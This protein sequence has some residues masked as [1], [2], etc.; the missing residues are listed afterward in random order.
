MR[1]AYDYQTFTQQ[2]YGGISRYYVRLAEQLSADQQQVRIFA[3]FHR[4]RHVDELPKGLLQGTQLDKFPPRTARLFSMWNR[5][6]SKGSID[7]W[8]PDVVHETYYAAKPS[9]DEHLPR[10]VTIHDMIH[11]R[12]PQSFSRFDHSSD[13]KRASLARA[14]H[15][16]CI[17]QNTKRDLMELFGTPEEKIS[18]IYHGFDQMKKAPVHIDSAPGTRPFLLYVGHRGGYKNF[19]GL[20]KAVASSERLLRDFDIVAFGGGGFTQEEQQMFTE[21]KFKEGQIRQVGGSDENLGRL[22]DEAKAFVYPSVYEGFGLPPLE[23][24]A[25]R[26]PVMSSNSSSMPEVISDAAAFFDPNNI[27]NIRDVLETELYSDT[28]LQDLVNKGVERLKH[29]S[30]DKCAKETLTAYHKAAG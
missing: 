27:D 18:V 13:L 3:P 6:V 11:E 25:H 30:W 9:G 10:V 28:R 21:L 12:F 17:S 1:I 4:N 5:M 16:I 8:A 15:I 26:C 24:M 14:D 7:R 19:S 29:F 23:A 20:V 22:Y 2:T